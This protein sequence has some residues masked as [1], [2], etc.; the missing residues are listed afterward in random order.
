MNK[1]LGNIQGWIEGGY[2]GNHLQF[3]LSNSAEFA[4]TYS[5]RE[6][7]VFVAED[8]AAGADAKIGTFNTTNGDFQ[9][10]DVEGITLPTFTPDQEFEMRSGTGRV[11]QLESMYNNSKGVVTEFTLSGRLDINTLAILMQNVT[12]TAV[13]TNEDAEADAQN[14][15]FIAGGGAYSPT[16][17]EHGDTVAAD[18]FNKTLSVYFKAP[19]EDNSYQFTGCV[20]TSLEIS[21]DMGT[22]SGRFNYSA[23]FQTGY[24]PTKGSRSMSG[25][26]TIGANVFMTDLGYRYMNMINADASG[27]DYYK[28]TPIFNSMSF[29]IESPSVMLGAQGSNNEPQ[30]IARAVPEL[31]ITFGGSLKYDT[32][33]D[34]LLEAHRDPGQNS[35]IQ[36]FG[37]T[38]DNDSSAAIPVDAV[39]PQDLAFTDADA[40][41]LGILFH[42]A[43]LISASVG[44]GD[45][46]TIDFEAK[47]VDG[48]STY[49]V[50][51]VAVGDTNHS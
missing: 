33:T 13:T 28:M 15:V 24:A 5:G 42:K 17:L 3:D 41:G 21:A 36:F 49:E 29:T 6:F 43:K 16:H 9:Q 20:C 23:T 19:E 26:G 35:Y 37:A 45:V 22:A 14:V 8:G 32:D 11:A 40:H 12:A 48:G 27:T 30:V 39:F 38:H 25:H 10:F 2:A 50:L 18:A 46:A 44:S 4:K 47:V 31:N 34:K 1:L 7:S 51:Q